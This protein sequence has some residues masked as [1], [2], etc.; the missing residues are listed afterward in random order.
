[1]TNNLLH[2]G[3]TPVQLIEAVND[4]LPT[5]K[6]IVVM[7]EFTDGT[8]GVYYND[9]QNAYEVIGRLIAMISKIQEEQQIQ[10]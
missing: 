8:N 9:Q 7:I 1:M 3:Y 2:I 4:T 6:N 5:I 10:A